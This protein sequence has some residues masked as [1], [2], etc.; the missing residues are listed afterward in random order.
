MKNLG[1]LHS[2]PLR[3]VWVHEALAFTT[4]LSEEENLTLLGDELDLDLSLMETEASIGKFNVD[5]LAE[6]SLTGKKVVIENQL[7]PTNHDHLGKLITYASGADASYVIWVVA[8]ERDEHQRAIDWLNEHTDDDVSF[9]L[10]RVE[11]WKIGDSLPAPKFVVVSKPNNWAKAAKHAATSSAV[12]SDLK[13]RQLA[14]WEALCQEGAKQGSPLSFRKPQPHHWYDI[15]AGTTKWHISLT[16]NSQQDTMACGVYIRNDKDLFQLF[17]AHRDAIE[18]KIGSS[19]EWLELAEKKASRI[20][21]SAPCNLDI[22][23]QWPSYI[24]WLLASATH[25]LEVF[26]SIKG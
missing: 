4:W 18:E 20:K 25:F 16:L 12:K 3:D 21:L 22:E 26:G 7:E 8:K 13:L 14:F 11:L 15:A 23:E 9:F 6:E 10:V 24:E 17:L 19:L 1:N 5:I 2:V